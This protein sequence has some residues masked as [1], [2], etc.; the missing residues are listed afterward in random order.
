VRAR[1]P[2][3]EDYVERDGVRVWYEVYGDAPTTIMLFSGWALPLRAWKMQIAYLSR[4]YRVIAFDQRGTGRSDRPLGTRAYAL[5]EHVG[6]ALAI[7]DAVGAGPVVLLGKSRGVQTA[8]TLAADH[9]ERVDALIAGA[10]MIPLSRWPPLDSIWSVFEEPSVRERKRAVVRMSLAGVRQLTQSGDLRRWVRRI[11][12]LEAADRFSRQSILDDF[13]GFAQ[14]FTTRIVATDPHSTKQTDD[15]IGWLIADGPQAVADSFIG[16]CVRD[17][18]E[19]RALCERVSCPVLVIHGDRDFTIPF[20]WGR[21]FAELTG[22]N[23]LAIPGAGH[24]PGGRYPVVVN[25]AIRE[26][27]DSL[28]GRDDQAARDVRGAAR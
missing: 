16:S 8:L 26:F 28:P 27:V 25:L 12:S 21:R 22:G 20:E 6:D 11:N 1:N 14:W 15:L 9:P 2:D 3:R 7:M 10:P 24:L 4:H 13:G 23:L 17:P 19:A 18:A 5:A